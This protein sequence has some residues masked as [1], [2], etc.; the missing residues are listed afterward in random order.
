MSAVRLAL[1]A[2]LAACSGVAQA[3]PPRATRAPVDPAHHRQAVA[4]NTAGLRFYKSGQLPRAALR[5]RDAIALDPDYVLAHY[6]LA[7]ASSRLRESAAALAE[8]QWLAA[9]PDP[10][11]KVKLDKALVDPDLDF[12]SALPVVRE[13]LLLAPF[14]PEHPLAWLAERGG[15][16][17]A[18]LPREDCALRSYTFEVQNDGDLEL[19]VREQCAPPAAPKVHTFAGSV[20]VDVDGAVRFEVP[21]WNQWPRDV[22]LRFTPCPGLD[23]TASC[24]VL[25]AAKI[26]IGPFHRGVAGMSPMRARKNLAAAQ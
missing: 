22:R 4:A 2:L 24:F 14:D 18:E 20:R 5:F 11:A 8:L 9:S 16:W 7:C 26:E 1:L 15:V 23:A 13:L 6:N 3:A 17:S 12:V 19:T 25:D 21:T 10:R